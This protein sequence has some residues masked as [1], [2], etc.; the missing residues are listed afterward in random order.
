MQFTRAQTGHPLSV[1]QYQLFY[2][3]IPGIPIGLTG[4][5]LVY[6]LPADPK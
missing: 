4:N 2:Q 1:V 3:L 6:R 5:S